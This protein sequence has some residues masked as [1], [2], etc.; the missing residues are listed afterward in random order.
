VGEK[1]SLRN[2]FLP[3]NSFLGEGRGI[4]NLRGAKK[5]GLSWK[6]VVYVRTG[7]VVAGPNQFSL[8]STLKLLRKLKLL[9]PMVDFAPNVQCY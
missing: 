6:K 8:L 4:L 5:I 7:L 2:I 3:K 1:C 9:T